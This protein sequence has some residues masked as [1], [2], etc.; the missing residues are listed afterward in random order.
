MTGCCCAVVVDG[1]TELVVKCMAV[2]RF[3]EAC[4]SVFDPPLMQVLEWMPLMR[5]QIPLGALQQ[6]QMDSKLSM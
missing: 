5:L 3:P 1:D 4:R 6:L 2:R